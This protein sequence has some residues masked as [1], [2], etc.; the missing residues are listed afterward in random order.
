MHEGEDRKRDDHRGDLPCDRVEQRWRP[1]RLGR[2]GKP[3]FDQRV[4]DLSER[5]APETQGEKVQQVVKRI[6]GVRDAMGLGRG[7]ELGQVFGG[8]CGRIHEPS[9]GRRTGAER[10]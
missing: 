8:R 6:A 9:I 4:E 10:P 2:I 7:D 1:S 5:N 3:A